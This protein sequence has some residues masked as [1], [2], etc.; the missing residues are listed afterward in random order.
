MSRITKSCWCLLL[1]LLSAPLLAVGQ[2]VDPQAYYIDEDGEEQVTRE[3]NKGEAPLDVTFRANPSD[4]DGY[5]PSFEWHFRQQTL[6]EGTI[7]L[8]VRYEEDT[9]Y[10]FRESG[11]YNVVLKTRLEQDG[12]ELDSVTIVVTIPESKLEFP[13]AFSPNDDG[14]NDRYGAYGVNDPESPKHWKS[15]VDFHAYIFNRW[16]QKLYEWHDPAGYWD[17]KYN[18]KDVREGVYF[19]LVKAKG[20]DGKVYDIRKD[21][22]LLR[23]YREKESG[24]DSGGSTE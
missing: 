10:T 2:K 3:V 12:A 17:G 9:Q 13:N 23:G 8:F 18:G 22:N 5:T 21:V 6:T 7:D 15:I 16:G 19:V 20:A 1:A 14:T 24:G 4:M 11:T